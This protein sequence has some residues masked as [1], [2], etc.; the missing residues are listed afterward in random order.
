MLKNEDEKILAL[1]HDIVEDTNYTLEDVAALGFQDLSE[2]LD[3]LS[4][5]KDE[6]YAQFVSRIMKS[7][8]AVKVK[9]ADI[10]HNLS[11]IDSLPEHERGL[12]DRYKKWL[13]VLEKELKRERIIA[14]HAG[15]GKASLAK[16]YPEK[17]IDFVSMPYKYIL[18]KKYEENDSESCKANLDYQP[19]MD[20]PYNYRDAI[21]AQLNKSDKMLLVP[22]DWRLLYM[23]YVAEVPYMLCYPENTAEAKAAY[24]K[25]YKDRGNS[26]S[27]LKLFIDGWDNFM[28]FLEKDDNCSR[29]LIL[30]PHQFLA[31]VVEEI[32]K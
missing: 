13:P 29:K 15:T 3:C 32:C 11:R 31:D 2:S 21:L 12:A 25:R 19:N 6:T 14:A 7:R 24:R 10:K 22:P 16:Q 20:W 1:L 18:P 4:R 27:F 9:V 8:I 5:K 28:H 26:K 30:K 23:L 17:F